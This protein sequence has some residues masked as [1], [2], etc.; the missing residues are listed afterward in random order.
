MSSSVGVLVPSP[1]AIAFIVESIKTGFSYHPIG[2]GVELLVIAAAI[3]KLVFRGKIL[4]FLRVKSIVMLTLASYW[5][6]LILFVAIRIEQTPL[7]GRI[8]EFY[9]YS[10]FLTWLYPLG[11]KTALK[12]MSS[13]QLSLSAIL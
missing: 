11:L 12:T 13:W 6:Y 10:P 1:T 7:W 9:T 2:K 5:L 4:A 8:I 3:W